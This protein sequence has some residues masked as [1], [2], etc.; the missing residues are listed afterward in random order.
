MSSIGECGTNSPVTALKPGTKRYA[1]VRAI[2]DS[3]AEG[4]DCFGAVRVAH[5]FVLRSTVSEVQSQYGLAISRRPHVV[6]NSFGGETHCVR[7]WIEGA[8]RD[9]AARL[10]GM[11]EPQTVH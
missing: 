2:L 9:H 10:L 1:V 4:L 3:G 7:Y 6:P 5:D 11:A 8:E